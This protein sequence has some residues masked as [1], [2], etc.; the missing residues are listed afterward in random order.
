[1]QVSNA[2]AVFNECSELHFLDKMKKVTVFV[3]LMY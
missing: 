2:A 3:L 1:M